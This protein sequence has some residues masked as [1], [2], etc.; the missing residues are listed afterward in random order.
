MVAP[1]WDL[2]SS[3]MMGS[4]CLR[5]RSGQCPVLAMKT[6]TQFTNPQPACR[7][8]STYHFVASSL[9]TGR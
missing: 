9:P 1:T 7:I 8:C 4:P 2:M 3:P 6:G 5:N